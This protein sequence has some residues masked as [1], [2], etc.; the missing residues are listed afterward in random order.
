MYIREAHPTDGRQS[1]ANVRE[2]IL[3][4][5]PKTL[6]A[7]EEVARDFAS[8]FKVSLPIL[9]DTIDNKVDKA[10]S[11]KPDRIYVIDAK[12]KVAYKGGPGPR[13]FKVSDVPITLDKLLGTDLASRA[14][15]KESPSRPSGGNFPF[16]SM[17]RPGQVLPMMMMRRLNLDQKQRQQIMDLQRKAQRQ[18]REILTEEQQQ[19]LRAMMQRRPG[20]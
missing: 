20:R 15:V 10:Y 19:K 18:L 2:G 7:R 16:Q 9:V 6:A 5:D 1:Q 3:I 14:G 11:A 13:G 12:G 17:T 8:Q 4:E